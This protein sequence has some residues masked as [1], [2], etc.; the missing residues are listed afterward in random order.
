[1]LL[2][3]VL[4]YSGKGIG[5]IISKVAVNFPVI[6][7]AII[8]VKIIFIL[9]P[10]FAEIRRSLNQHGSRTERAECHNQVSKM[11][12]HIQI[13]ANGHILKNCQLFVF[14]RNLADLRRINISQCILCQ[15]KL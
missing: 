8:I 4:H 14:F 15:T 3:R 2:R 9:K 1:M 7:N 11:E 6:F 10:S 5:A 12:F 13:E